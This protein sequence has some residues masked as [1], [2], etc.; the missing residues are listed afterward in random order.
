[1]NLNVL[2]NLLGLL[3]DIRGQLASGLV[4]ASAGFLWF[5]H[6]DIG[7]SILRDGLSDF[8]Q[9][10]AMVACLLLFLMFGIAISVPLGGAA[11][12]VQAW[13]KKLLFRSRL[14]HLPIGSRTILLYFL[15]KRSSQIRAPKDCRELNILIEREFAWAHDRALQ[16]SGWLYG[17]RSEAWNMLNGN[18]SYLESLQSR[19]DAAVKEVWQ[20]LN[21]AQPNSRRI[22]VPR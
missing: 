6:A 2:V 5:I 18:R 15:E 21:E 8:S 3:K 14:K 19:G 22:T 13:V 12:L 7:L 16:G 9:H 10:V 1:M 11:N 4:V 17:L 20:R